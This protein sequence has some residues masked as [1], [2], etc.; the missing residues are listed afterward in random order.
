[1]SLESLPTPFPEPA[2][3]RGLRRLMQTAAL[4]RSKTP[5]HEEAEVYLDEE[6]RLSRLLIKLQP[7]GAGG[8]VAQ[9]A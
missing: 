8:D 5:D 2:K 7:E 1:M 9:L 4:L 3:V 6:K